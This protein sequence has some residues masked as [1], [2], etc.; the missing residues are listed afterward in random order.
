MKS[1]MKIYFFKVIFL[2]FTRKL[3]TDEKFLSSRLIITFERWIDEVSNAK[4]CELS[5]RL[6]GEKL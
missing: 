2:L 1:Y 5:L 4:I 3:Q 6:S